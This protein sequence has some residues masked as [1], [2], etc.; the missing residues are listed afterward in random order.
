M[1]N[2]LYDVVEFLVVEVWCALALAGHVF[3]LVEQC[4]QN[5][6]HI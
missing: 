1:D 3:C 6:A 5:K 4:V 2:M